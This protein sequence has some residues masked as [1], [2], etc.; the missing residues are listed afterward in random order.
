MLSSTAGLL[1]P[2]EPAEVVQECGQNA[3]STP[4][5]GGLTASPKLVRQPEKGR[6]LA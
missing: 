1:Y 6:E 2:K 5:F 3:P 4:P